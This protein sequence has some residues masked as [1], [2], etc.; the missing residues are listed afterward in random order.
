MWVTQHLIPRSKIGENCGSENAKLVLGDIQVTLQWDSNG[1]EESLIGQM[2]ISKTELVAALVLILDLKTGVETN[3]KIITEKK[4]NH[5]HVLA[6]SCACKMQLIF[7]HVWSTLSTKLFCP[8]SRFEIT[9]WNRDQKLWMAILNLDFWVVTMN[10]DFE[11]K[12]V[13][14]RSIEMVK[15]WL[16]ANTPLKLRY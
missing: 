11:N 8:I 7:K 6:K 3:V 15:E 1:I 5:Y 14:H 9:N 13:V 2:I 12:I 10:C 4:V 16:K